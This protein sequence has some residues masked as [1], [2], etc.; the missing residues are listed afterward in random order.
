MNI[1]NETLT[2]CQIWLSLR[3]VLPSVVQ[4]KLLVKFT[5]QYHAPMKIIFA[6][7]QQ[8][9]DSRTTLALYTPNDWL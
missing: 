6:D 1:N 2:L 5:R 9:F 3:I 4:E 7:N 8:K